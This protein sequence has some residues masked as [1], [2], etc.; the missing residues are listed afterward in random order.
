MPLK[1]Y[2]TLPLRKFLRAKVFLCPYYQ[3]DS[4]GHRGLPQCYTLR[5]RYTGSS[6]IIKQEGRRERTSREGYS[7]CQFIDQSVPVPK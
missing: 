6:G 4:C 2:V 5:L 7:S 1:Q 3:R